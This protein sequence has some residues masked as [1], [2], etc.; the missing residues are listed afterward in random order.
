MAGTQDVEY[1]AKV[2]KV[3]NKNHDTDKIN[4]SCNDYKLIVGD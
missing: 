1:K 4:E 2:P 3:L